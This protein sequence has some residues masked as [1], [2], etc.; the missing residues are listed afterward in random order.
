MHYAVEEIYH[1]PLIGPLPSLPTLAMQILGGMFIEDFMF[2]WLHRGLHHRRI[3]K[4]IHKV[5]RASGSPLYSS[6]CTVLPERHRFCARP[7]QKHH[8]FRY[9]VGFGTEYSHPV[10]GLLANTIP[11]FLGGLIMG[12]NLP[13]SLLWYATVTPWS[14][15][16]EASFLK[17]PFA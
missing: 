5:W 15:F 2:Y 16:S 11:S 12:M 8:D 9:T 4:Y 13:T 3:Y 6:S 1:R 7:Q 10:E 14:H 17:L